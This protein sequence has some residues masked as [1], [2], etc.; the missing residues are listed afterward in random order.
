MTLESSFGPNLSISINLRGFVIAA[1]ARIQTERALQR[2]REEAEKQDALKKV[3]EIPTANSEEQIATNVKLI[4]N[5][6]F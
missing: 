6:I 4:L 2:A 3:D 1:L 5:V